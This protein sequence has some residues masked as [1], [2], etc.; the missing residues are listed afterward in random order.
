MIYKL[1]INITYDSLKDSPKEKMMVVLC[2]D[3]TSVHGNPGYHYSWALNKKAARNIFA[4]FKGHKKSR[5]RTL[6]AAH[7]SNSS[8]HLHWVLR[9]YSSDVPCLIDR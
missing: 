3:V 5:G 6:S 9:G 8:V 4:A 2:Y 1:R 7:G